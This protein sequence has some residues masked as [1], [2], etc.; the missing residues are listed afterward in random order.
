MK[1]K[2][3]HTLKTHTVIAA[4]VGS[5]R[6]ST[7]SMPNS[8]SSRGTGL[9]GVATSQFQAVADTTTGTTQGSNSSTLNAPL[10]GIRVRSSKANARPSAHDPNTPTIVKM[11]VNRVAF[12]NASDV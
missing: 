3:I 8:P 7:S 1:G 2:L 5:A 6:N 9:C 12:Q 4:R 11:T 10:P